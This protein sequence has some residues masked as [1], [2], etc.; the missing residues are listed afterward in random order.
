MIQP[1]TPYSNKT[2]SFK[3]LYSLEDAD[4]SKKQVEIMDGISKRLNHIILGTKNLTYLKKY[5]E[6]DKW[7]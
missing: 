5:E 4:Y 3:A 7:C 6:K 2:P 1:I